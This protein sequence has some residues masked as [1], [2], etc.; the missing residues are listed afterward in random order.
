MDLLPVLIQRHCKAEVHEKNGNLTLAISGSMVVCGE[1]GF[2]MVRR[3]GTVVVCLRKFQKASSSALP[4]LVN[5]RSSRFVG[6]RSERFSS[7]W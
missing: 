2:T 4:G 3:R 1:G 5:R 7:S 6:Q